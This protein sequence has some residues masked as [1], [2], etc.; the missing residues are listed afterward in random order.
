MHSCILVSP[1]GN[2]SYI[3]LPPPPEFDDNRSIY[4][5]RDRGGQGVEEWDP[6]MAHLTNQG[7]RIFAIRPTDGI[8]SSG[9]VAAGARGFKMAGKELV[10]LLGK[11]KWKQM[12][13]MMMRERDMVMEKEMPR[14]EKSWKTSGRLKRGRPEGM[15]TRWV[16]GCG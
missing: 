7:N 3:D 13:A 14:N 8:L 6:E 15:E 10:G 1:A 12:L 11:N 2:P 5:R 16:G 9:N 4:G